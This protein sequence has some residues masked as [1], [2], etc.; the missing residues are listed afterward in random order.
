M[1]IAYVDDID[2]LEFIDE[3]EYLTKYSRTGLTKKAA[4]ELAAYQMVLSGHCVSTAVMAI[5]L[6]TTNTQRIIRHSVRC[7]SCVTYIGRTLYV[8]T[9][10]NLYHVIISDH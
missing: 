4:M 1:H 6:T 9:F 10:S 3:G 5:Q 7:Q 8:R 2:D